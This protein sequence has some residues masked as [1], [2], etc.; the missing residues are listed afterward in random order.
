MSNTLFAL[1]WWFFGPIL[2]VV[3]LTAIALVFAPTGAPIPR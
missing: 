1:R 2:V 3:V